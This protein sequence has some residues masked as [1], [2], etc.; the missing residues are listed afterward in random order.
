M[1]EV[2]METKFAQFFK[3]IVT[4]DRVF[5]K[6]VFY[7]PLATAICT[8]VFNWVALG[9]SISSSFSVMAFVFMLWCFIG[10]VYVAISRKNIR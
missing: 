4:S 8:F 3:T 1:G 10:V 6:A 7:L 9:K 2:T 5:L